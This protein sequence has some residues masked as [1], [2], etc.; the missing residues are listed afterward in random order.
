[1]SDK[2]NNEMEFR[3]ILEEMGYE[4]PEDEPLTE[5]ELRQVFIYNKIMEGEKDRLG[6]LTAKIDE[7]NKVIN[8]KKVYTTDKIK[9]SPIAYVAGAFLG[10]IFVGYIMGKGKDKTL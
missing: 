1:M 10:G 8:E 2:K 3:K 5:Q 9:E 7:L 4:K 6:I